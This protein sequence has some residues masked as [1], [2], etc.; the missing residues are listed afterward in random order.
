MMTYAI[1]A[2]DDTN[3][4]RNISKNNSAVLNGTTY[5]VLSENL[6]GLCFDYVSPLLDAQKPNAR[7]ATEVLSLARKTFQVMERYPAKQ[8]LQDL[9]ERTLDGELKASSPL[10]NTSLASLIQTQVQGALD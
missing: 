1:V 6:S 5:A 10:K 9:L 4:G 8:E 2:F 3:P 7:K